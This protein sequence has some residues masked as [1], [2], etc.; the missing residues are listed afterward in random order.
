LSY[1]LQNIDPTI[2]LNYKKRFTCFK[3]TSYLISSE[4]KTWNF[5]RTKL[6]KKETRD[7]PEKV[8]AAANVLWH[9]LQSILGSDVSVSGPQRRLVAVGWDRR[10]DL[11]QVLHLSTQISSFSLSPSI[12][13]LFVSGERVSVTTCTVPEPWKREEE[14]EEEALVLR[15]VRVRDPREFDYFVEVAPIGFGCFVSLL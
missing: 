14:E 9:I 1:L 3:E 6:N 8:P 7:P 2:Y 10:F 5:P 4:T 12:S 15:R 13:G 11:H